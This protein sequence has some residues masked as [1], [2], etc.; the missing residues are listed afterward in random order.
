M[1]ALITLATLFLLL[2]SCKKDRLT[3]NGD[4]KTERRNPGMF[5]GVSASG[6]N[7]IHIS[8]GEEYKVELKGSS[9]LIPYF[10]TKVVGGTL[11][12][13]YERAS[14]SRDDLVIY[15]TLPLLKNISLSG[16]AE[17]EVKGS[18]PLINLFQ[19][20][21]SGSGEVEVKDPMQANNINISV[22]G[23]GEVDLEKLG[24]R[25]VTTDISGSGDVR[26]KVEER[27]K[28]SISGSGKV[29]YTGSPVVESNISGSGKLIKF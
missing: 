10:S 7:A 1:K 26:V 24:A 18:F 20:D 28:A 13:N 29:Y 22:S 4:M 25:F 3:A 8:Y 11:N 27:L 16:S 9:N 2:V 14:V 12:L 19:V 23:S 17:V 15:V 5:T 6:S 21:V